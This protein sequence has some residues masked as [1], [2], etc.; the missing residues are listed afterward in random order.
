MQTVELSLNDVSQQQLKEMQHALGI[1]YKS[2]P[3]R[4]YFFVRKPYEN[5]EDLVRKGFAKKGTGVNGGTSTVYWLTYEAVKLV[6]GKR[7]SKNY[8]DGL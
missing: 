1:G 6:Y 4:N 2:K 8:Y 5:W 3:Y 7:I